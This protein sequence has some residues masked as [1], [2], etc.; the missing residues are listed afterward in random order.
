M[1]NYFNFEHCARAFGRDVRLVVG[2]VRKAVVPSN[3][4][5]FHKFSDPRLLR[6]LSDDIP[7][8]ST[9]ES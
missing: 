9:F 7:N 8:Y 4:F 6:D 3:T 1:L 2:T 5:N